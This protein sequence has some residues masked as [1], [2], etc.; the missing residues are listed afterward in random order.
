MTS[1]HSRLLGLSKPWPWACAA[2]A[3]F[4]VAFVWFAGHRG[5]FLLDQSIMFDGAWRVYQGQVQYR[6]FVSAFPP[7]PFAIQAL[8]FHLMGVDFAAMVLAGAISNAIAALCVV[9]LVQRFVPDQRAIAL[10]AGLLTAVWFQAPFGTFW[11]EQTAFCFN[12]LALILLLKG[13]DAKDSA[14]V[15][16]RVGAGV[17]LAASL[18]CK[19]NAGAE[20]LPLAFGVAVL[21]VLNQ[22][23]KAVRSAIDVLAGMALGGGIFAIWL[24]IF[25]SPPEFWKEYV[26]MA[27]QIGSDRAGLVGLLFALFPLSMTLPFVLVPLGVLG[28]A[29]SKSRTA[30]MSSTNRVLILWIV[31]GG[32]FYQ[33]LFKLHTDNEIENA[34]PFLGLIYGLSFAVFW[35]YTVLAETSRT[36][37]VKRAFFVGLGCLVLG[38]PLL[39]GLNVSW[40]RSVQEFKAG[41][42]FNHRA[43]VPGL[44]RVL[45]GEPTPY[46]EL[47][48]IDWRD[49]E[50]L[51]A[52][53]TE[54]Q[55]NFFVFPDSTML[56]GLHGRISPQPWLYFSPGHSFLIEDL[57][58]V[59]AA[60]L[61]SLQKNNVRA[62]VLEKDSWVL[63]HNLWKEMPKLK[64]WIEGDFEKVKDF[65]IYDVRLSKQVLQSQSR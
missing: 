40:S 13:L 22:K 55:S 19:Q 54:T 7:L 8:F 16:F 43:Q 36:E 15:T 30:A 9:W 32:A 25:S 27:R 48:T 18:L 6:D 60:V 21:P 5:V 10:I 46:G 59:D 14:A 52:W 2:V 26:V 1:S 51:N 41:A 29:F 57:H 3:V 28:A 37:L 58:K 65:G 45:W 49:F 44:S 33:N 62:I 63:N 20:F 61:E 34:V 50:A 47:T 31:I 24:W 11:F 23:K 56:Y 12:L 35:K 4:A 42:V 38:Y 53:L 64:A 39:H 17:M